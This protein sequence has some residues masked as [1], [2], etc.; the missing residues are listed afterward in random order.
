MKFF[1]KRFI[2]MPKKKDTV[3]VAHRGYSSIA[4]ENTIP[5]FEEAVQYG[6]GGVECDVW[7]T[8]GER[9][10]LM[11]LHDENLLRMCGVDRLITELTPEQIAQY[12]I[13]QGE[14][15]EKYGGALPIPSYH[16]YLKVL[17]GTEVIPV[18]EIKSKSPADQT[19]EISDWAAEELV[20][21]LYENFEG[22]KA[23]L[24]S[25][26]MASLLKVKPLLNKRME[27]ELLYLTKKKGEVRSHQLEKLKRH[28]LTGV[29]VKHTIASKEMIARTHELGLKV[30]V[31]TVDK[32]E[33]AAKLAKEDHT[34]FIISNKKVFL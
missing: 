13:R 4:P 1:Q 8:A 24:Q 32:I 5:A 26:N 21:R 17:A 6:F 9:P 20:K 27:I 29:C 19:N 15:I 2:T 23:V 11:I 3:F 34:D 10:E 16:Q 14:N 7:Q 28:G 22:K 25:F 33:L 12:P 18:I 31:W 30:G